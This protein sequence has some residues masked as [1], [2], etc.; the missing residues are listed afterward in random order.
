[1]SDARTVMTDEELGAKLANLK[2]E[3]AK[4]QNII[5]KESFI[6]KGLRNDASDIETALRW[7]RGDGCPES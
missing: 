4:R 1:M 6:L 2:Y 5:E 3:I 7:R